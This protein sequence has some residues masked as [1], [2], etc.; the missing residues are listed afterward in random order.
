MRTSTKLFL[1]LA[2]GVTVNSSCAIGSVS[3]MVAGITEEQH[4]DAILLTS[5]SY[6]VSSIKALEVAT[7]GGSIQVTGDAS[8]EAVLEMYV[9]SG[10]NRNLSK[11]EIEE[12]LER[13]YEISIEERNGTLE[14][15]AKRKNNTNWKNSISISFKIRTGNKVSTE[16]NTSG[17]SIQLYALN[18]VQNF[19]TSG[20]SLTIENVEGQVHGRTSGGSIKALNS[21]GSIDLST[22][23]GSIR[24]EDLSGDIKAS[25][26]GGSIKGSSIKGS[27]YASTSGGSVNL[28]DLSCAVR[29]STSGGSVTAHLTDMPGDVALSTSAGSVNLQIPANAQANLDLK[30]M[31]VNADRL[32]NFNGSNSKG[33][34]V[35]SINGGGVQVTASTSAGSVNLSFN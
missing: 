30:G 18:G 27:L 5:K 22:S 21:M 8:G 2:I 19:K 23:G 34:L 4:N 10:N 6:P 35:G 11:S 7:S 15:I 12:V 33:K 26:S 25:T 16:L 24:L 14:A 32:T 20:G 31:K 9:R 28:D 17:G 3:D 13:D 1:M 29:A